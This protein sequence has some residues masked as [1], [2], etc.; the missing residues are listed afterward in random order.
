MADSFD[1]TVTR[2]DTLRWSMF[3]RNSSGGS[4]DLN[5]STLRLQV[6]NGHW[7]SKLF[8][9]YEVGVTAG[10]VL[11]LFGGMTGGISAN[12]SGNILVCIGAN[13]TIN[14]PPYTKVFYDIQEEKNTG[15][16]NTLL[17]GNIEVLADVTRG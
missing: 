4:Y 10:S 13:D 16:V 6:R 14:F 15:D 3:V 11:T 9:S 12:S 8:A 2:G 7:P 5:G 17:S 1:P